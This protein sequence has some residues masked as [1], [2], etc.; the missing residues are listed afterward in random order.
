[1]KA[2]D[3]PKQ[4]FE[5]FAKTYGKGEIRT[6]GHEDGDFWQV[7][8]LNASHKG[9]GFYGAL[10]LQV[11]S[12]SFCSFVLCSFDKLLPKGKE[13]SLNELGG[14]ESMS[15]SSDSIYGQGVTFRTCHHYGFKSDLDLIEPCGRF[16][17][18]I[19]ARA[20][21]LAETIEK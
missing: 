16:A 2:Y 10:I 15:V 18:K 3:V 19:I 21:E 14:F 5:E 6:A 1:M 7:A 13:I 20:V 17:A 12:S 9:V 11:A 4:L 8:T